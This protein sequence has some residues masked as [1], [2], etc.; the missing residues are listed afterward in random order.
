MGKSIK[1]NNKW[2][3]E[4]NMLALYYYKL[5]RYELFKEI[6]KVLP[7]DDVITNRLVRLTGRNLR[8]L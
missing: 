2:T 1:D 8:K 5:N 4:A 6:K 7:I 3:D